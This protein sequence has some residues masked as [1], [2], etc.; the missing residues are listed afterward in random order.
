MRTLLLMRGAMGSGKN[1]WIKENKLEP[2]TL[3]AD[4]FRTQICNP[5]LDLEGNF[6]ISQKNDRI[7]WNMLLQCLEERMKR[8]DFT[9][10][11]ATHST[12]KMLNNYKALAEMYKYT[13]FVK[14][15]DVPL[16]TCLERNRTRDKYKFVPEE[17]IKRCHTLI[18][19]TELSKG[20]KKIDKIEEI[21]NF[22]VDNITDK[23]NRV[24]ITGDIHS[25]NNVLGQMFEKEGF[26]EDTLYVFLGD[27]L[28]RGIEHKETLK[29]M[30]YLSTLKNVI[31]LEG[32]HE[33]LSEDTEVL[34]DKGW[35]LVK[36]VNI[37]TDK[38][39][40]YDVNTQ[41]LSFEFPLN[42]IEKYSEKIIDIKTQWGHQ[43]VTPNHDILYYGIKV[44][45]KDL[46][47]NTNL[48]SK[49]FL[50]ETKYKQGNILP[51]TDDELRL[52]VQICMDATLIDHSKY[53]KNSIKRRIQFKLSKPRKISHLEELLKKMNIPY[54]KK[55]CK[56]TGLNKL[57]PYYI[58]IY[59][60]YA[61]YYH[62]IVLKNVKLFPE[63]FK[64]ANKHQADI[65]LDEIDITDGT[66]VCNITDWSSISKHNIDII[67]Q[68]CVFNNIPIK[69]KLVSKNYGFKNSKDIYNCTI[70]RKWHPHGIH[71]KVEIKEMEYNSLVYCLTMSKGTLITR[72]NG[73][74][75]ITGNCHLGG[76]CQGREIKS[77]KFLN[78]T[79]KVLIDGL[80]DEELEQL[81]SKLRQFYKK[82]RQA[83][84][85]E[86]EGKKYLCTHAGLP[87][88]PSLTYIA[89]D[90]MIK[91]IGDYEDDISGIYE[92][93]YALGKCQDFTQIF[94]HRANKCTEHSIN[95]EG[96]VEFGGN[97][98]YYVLEKGKEPRI[99]SIKNEVYDKDYFNREREKYNRTESKNLTQN[100]E[101][102]KLILSKLV[103]VKQC[104]PNLLSLNFGDSVFRKKQWND[105][106]I[107]ARGLFVDRE[108]GDVK[109][110]S[111]QK[112]WNLGERKE[113]TMDE[114]QKNIQ[115]P[116]IAKYKE[117][118]F[119]GLMSVV[120]GEVVLATKSTTQ[121][122]WKNYFQ[123]LWDRE[124]SNIKM[125]LQEF[126]SKENC[127][128]IFEVKSFKD[129]HIIDFDKEELVLLDVVKNN[130]EVNGVNIDINYSQRCLNEF[131]DYV[132]ALECKIIR[133]VDT[134]AILDDFEHFKQLLQTFK[135]NAF[136]GF[137][138]TDQKGF[139]F[140]WKSDY[141]L[142]WKSV[143]YCY[144]Y[145]L[146]HWQESFPFRICKDS[147]EINFMKWV[148][149]QDINWLKSVDYVDVI[150]R[151]KEWIK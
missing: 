132:R 94:G 89:T 93:N 39:L 114:L 38:V 29:R 65:I 116:L 121:G 139:M 144:Q 27:Y 129:K 124:N 7:A 51:Y 115:Y 69:I 31:L 52:I 134:V 143:R 5:I 63:C 41:E 43:K 37:S 125:Y 36:D 88:V 147:F 111:Y 79:L 66:R 26:R 84:A 97:L 23:Y 17:A 42:K 98:M 30:M 4:L 71:T 12:Q 58:R 40:Q 45:A 55:L 109:I 53:I 137:V 50:Y 83:Y 78:E 128:F 21:N 68:M 9:V 20:V 70:L 8:G 33:C 126:A 24:I 131:K 32:N 106:T 138:F 28:D 77:K 80:N 151:Y 145:Y 118:G 56:K 86:F 3:E 13:I 108:T 57:Q 102:N 11:N 72:Y 123:E 120:N 19:Q 95:L 59:G 100:E 76:W 14:Q 103:K 54:T 91:G 127:T 105:I 22:Y 1:Y 25:C 74:I 62:N 6:S 75:N 136:E 150:N 61:R 85:F 130:L 142:K 34:T 122:D 18:S 16:E 113:T 99:E 35:K 10:I 64:Y 101:V 87:S 48:N 141:Y 81:K 46:L 133:V 140:K 2:Y 47:N 117:N 104:E 107:K 90:D 49:G 82:Q 15:L 92:N 44:K 67:S 119:L 148:T 149:E 112:F 110:R 146:K 60:E 96:Q 135:Y 73:K